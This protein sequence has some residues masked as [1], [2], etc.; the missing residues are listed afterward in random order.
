MAKKYHMS[1][2][3]NGMLSEDRSAIGNLPQNV[4]I[5][6]YPQ[7]PYGLNSDLDDTMS[8]IDRQIGSDD[9]AARSHRSKSKY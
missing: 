1:K 6:P 8:G 9:S 4:V 7:A 5:K 3:G 2:R